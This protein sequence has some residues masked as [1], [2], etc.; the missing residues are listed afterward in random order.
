MKQFTTNYCPSVGLG[1]HKTF[2]SHSLCF[3]QVPLEL[4]DKREFLPKQPFSTNQVP[5]L[6][7]SAGRGVG[8]REGF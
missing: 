5:V 7:T 2:T 3:A 1:A 4:Y 8:C 6:T